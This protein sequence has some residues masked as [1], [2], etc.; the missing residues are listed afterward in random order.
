MENKN[1]MGITKGTRVEM[2]YMG[3][4]PNPIEYGTK[5][6]VSSVCSFGNG[7]I[8]LSVQWDNGRTLGVVLPKDIV[9]II[10]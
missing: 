9:R 7:E 8:Q 1:Q 6:T 5:G 3:D 2:V 10:D 4:D